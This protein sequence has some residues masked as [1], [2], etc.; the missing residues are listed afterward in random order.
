MPRF[1]G[2][3]ITKFA[4]VSSS[5]R[6][7]KRIQ[8]HGYLPNYRSTS[9]LRKDCS[10]MNENSIVDEA[11]CGCRISFSLR[12]QTRQRCSI[13][14]VCLMIDGRISLL[15]SHESINTTRD[16]RWFCPASSS[17]RVA[18]TKREPCQRSIIVLDRCH[19][20]HSIHHLPNRYLWNH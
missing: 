18:P 19:H 17:S 4:V 3:L 14:Q 20:H 11:W 16:L 6:W 2:D 13:V 7:R 10:N 1:N 9:P 15:Q 8:S 5:D 12:I